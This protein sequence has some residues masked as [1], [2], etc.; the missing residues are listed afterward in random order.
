MFYEPKD[1]H[2]LPHNPFNALV[3]PRPIGW[4]SSLNKEGVANLAPF[5]FFN[6]VSYFPPQ[7][8][9]SS[10]GTHEQGGLKDTVRNI[11]ETG[12]FVVNMATFPLR[13]AVNMTSIPAPHD[14]D[15][16]ALAGLEKAAS[17]VVNVPRVAAS[18]AHFECKHIQTLELPTAQEGKPNLVVFGE[19]VGIHI[20]DEM[21]V[22]GLVDMKAMEP[23]SRLGYKDFAK[24]GDLFSMERPNWPMED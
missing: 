5:S 22:D 15:E 24:L 2:N 23:I 4:I 10:T 13:E 1:G 9:F 11:E 7:V 12:E 17:N 6:G 8:M 14:E 20:K 3:L 18:P 21:L 19:V 16:F